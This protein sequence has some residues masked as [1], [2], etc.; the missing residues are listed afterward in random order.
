MANSNSPVIDLFNDVMKAKSPKKFNNLVAK[1][2]IHSYLYYILDESIIPDREYDELC[3]ELLDNIDSITHPHKHLLDTEALKAGSGF[4]LRKEDYPLI[5]QETA[6]MLLCEHKG[7][8][9]I[10]GR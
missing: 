10:P 9:Y 3:K 4:Q 1:Y 7:V 2:L 5:V 8:K 6:K